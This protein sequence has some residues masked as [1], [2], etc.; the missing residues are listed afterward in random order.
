M[1]SL[2]GLLAR[3]QRKDRKNTWQVPHPTYQAP[4]PVRLRYNGLVHVYIPFDIDPF[5]PI[6]ETISLQIV[7]Q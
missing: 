1:L 7:P 2:I 5:T 4:R 3:L 6:H